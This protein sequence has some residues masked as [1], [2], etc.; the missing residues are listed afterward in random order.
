[1]SG[2]ILISLTTR[3]N[4]YQRAQAAAVESVS[5]RM[6][7]SIE[8]IY[9]DND[10]VNQSQQILSAIQ[11]K[12]NGLAAVITEPVGTGMVQVAEAAAKAGIAWGVLNRDIDYASRIHQATGV[13][14]FEVGVDQEAVGHIHAAQL[15]KLASG[16]G[17][18]LYI[19]GPASGSAA[20]LRTQGTTAK[21]PANIDLKILKGNWTE[22]SGHKVV[23]SWLKLSTSKSH[24]FVA[25]VAQ[26]D[27]MAIGARKAFSEL[28]NIDERS[29]W[30]SLPFLGCD[31]LPETGQQYVRRGSMTATV[32]YPLVAG[33]ALEMYLKAKASGSPIAERTFAAP[34]SFPAVEALRPVALAQAR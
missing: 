27:A 23:A 19:E 7:A 14:V 21:K 20:R 22:E 16:G 9:A 4:D 5:K 31:G 24:G 13:P 29:H 28:T 10:S 11:A 3:E 8:I 30:L 33:I 34:T 26:D 15:E 17:T 2:K 6:G 12:N 1:M 18:V 32:V 25:V